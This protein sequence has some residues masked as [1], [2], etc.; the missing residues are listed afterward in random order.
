MIN[1][2][3]EVNKKNLYKLYHIKSSLNK[4]NF[5]VLQSGIRQVMHNSNYNNSVNKNPYN[6]V[7][8]ERILL[9]LPDNYEKTNYSLY[10][11]I[12]KRESYR[13]FKNEFIDED[14][15]SVLLKL[16]CG[17]SDVYNSKQTIYKHF[18]YPSAGAINS[19]RIIVIIRKVHNIKNGIYLY[20]AENHC[21]IRIENQDIVNNI[22]IP[23]DYVVNSSFSI[24]IYGSMLC[25]GL[26]YNERA[27]RLLNIEAGH[28]IQNVYLLATAKNLGV[29]SSGGILDEAEES[30]SKLFNDEILA[31]YEVFI[32]VKN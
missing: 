29:V 12:L 3:K 9:K 15:L 13:Q 22:S 24:H 21:L 20:D 16:S 31:L 8:G 23:F 14:T 27:Y 18:V 26:K 7:N 30:L 25:K 2:F 32:G 6:I 1:N 10:E 5:H 11:T 4:T 28:I 17:M 19:L